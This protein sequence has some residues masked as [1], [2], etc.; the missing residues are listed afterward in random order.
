MSNVLFFST[1]SVGR[2]SEIAIL[3]LLYMEPKLDAPPPQNFIRTAIDIDARM[4]IE[5]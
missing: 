4:R 1:G 5:G 3:L 2:R